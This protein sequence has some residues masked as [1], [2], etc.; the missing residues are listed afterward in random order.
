MIVADGKQTGRGQCGSSCWWLAVGLAALVLMPLGCGT[1]DNKGGPGENNPPEVF[2]VNVPP[3]RTEFDASPMV[4]WYG[5]DNDGRIVRY[6]YAV[7][8]EAQVDSIAATLPGNLPAVDK[9]IAFV[10]NDQYPW[11]ISVFSDSVTNPTRQ[12]IKLYAS[13]LIA[14]CESLTVQIRDPNTGALTD[15]I[16]PVNCVSDTIPQYV[17]VRAIDDRGAVSK[18][19]YRS[20]T[21]RNHWPDTEIPSSF[22]RQMEYI[23]LPKLS[24]AYAGIRVVW[25]GSDNLDFRPPATPDLRYHW[26]IFG[27][28]AYNVDKPPTLAD[29]LGMEPVWESANPDTLQGVWVSDTAAMVYNLWRV[30][31]RQPDPLNDTTRTRSGWFALVV[32]AR[33]DAFIADATPAIATFKAIYPKFE[34]K[35]MMVDDTWYGI[36]CFTNPAP[37]PTVYSPNE[38]QAFL[39]RMLQAAYPQADTLEDWWWRSKEPP[40]GENCR[41]VRRVRCGNYLSLE[42]LAQHRLVIQ[43]SDDIVNPIVPS[44]FKPPIQAVMR[45]YLDAGGMLWIIG[46]HTLMPET[47]IC[48]GCLPVLMDLCSEESSY[49]SGPLACQYFDIEGMYYPA[50]QRTAIPINQTEPLPPSSNDEFIGAQLVTPGS[51]LPPV[52]EIDRARVDSL[53]LPPTLKKMLCDAGTCNITGVPDVDFLVRGSR[54]TPLYVFQS[55]R[56]LGPIPPEGGRSASHGKVVAIRMVG[57]SKTAPL[58]KTAYFSFP[59]Y[60]L[61]EEQAREVFIKM[62]EWFFLPFSQ[63]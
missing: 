39:V 12:R 53:Y 41:D 23:S 62:T 31:D 49:Y 24:G 33:D 17:F 9:F 29:T 58:Y 42:M 28:Y 35:V 60:F 26:R 36:D 43:V 63:S 40:P 46:R 59:M 22:D 61:K 32:R 20:F 15:S 4:Y 16:V 27:P 11:W 8:L 34:R 37:R 48:Q 14:D 2:L 7:V 18:T 44:T 6:D 25:G 51:G 45:R 47:D 3:D 30:A 10:L 56:P 21:R 52:L 5:T 19:K 57:P 54:S 1:I 55:W 13:P 50:W 38:N